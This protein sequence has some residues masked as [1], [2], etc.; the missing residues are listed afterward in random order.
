MEANRNQPPTHHGLAG[1]MFLVSG[2]A[3][4][5][6]GPA[7]AQTATLPSTKAAPAE[8]VQTGHRTIPSTGVIVPQTTVDPGMKVKAP[9]MPAETTPIIRPE[10]TPPN[11]GGAVVPR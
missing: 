9:A 4:L 5:A 6:T 11:E 8:T 3:L 10:Q 2:L 7:S 1:L